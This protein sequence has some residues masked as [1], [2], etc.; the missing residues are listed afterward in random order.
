MEISTTEEFKDELANTQ[1]P[2]IAYFSASWCGPCRSFRP[3]VEEV[4]KSWADKV[5]FLSVDVDGSPEL[6]E[7]YGIKSVPTIVVINTAE[8]Y[9]RLIGSKSLDELNNF[10]QGV[11]E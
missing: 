7:T 2:V 11:V 1:L 9:T 10:I 8:N 3:R 6:V 4:S 5:V